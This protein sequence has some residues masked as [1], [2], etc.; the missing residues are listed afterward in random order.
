MTTAKAVLVAGFM[1]AVALVLA[2]YLAAP[3]PYHFH[4]VPNATAGAR[5]NAITGEVRYCVLEVEQ[6]GA[7]AVFRCG[8]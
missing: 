8:N 3:G 2:G 5:I 6:R 7:G 1:I 4:A